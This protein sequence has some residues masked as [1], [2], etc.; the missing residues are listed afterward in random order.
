MLYSKNYIFMLCI[1]T[2]RFINIARKFKVG[3]LGL[4]YEKKIHLSISPKRYISEIQ[5]RQISITF[6]QFVDILIKYR[7]NLLQLS[8]YFRQGKS[9]RF[10]Y[11]NI[12]PSRFLAIFIFVNEATKYTTFLALLQMFL[13]YS[14]FVKRKNASSFCITGCTSLIMSEHFVFWLSN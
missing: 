10:L 7:L 9:I 3:F 8:W 6:L 2:S 11:K 13:S 4:K 5:A 1:Y 12:A 14:R